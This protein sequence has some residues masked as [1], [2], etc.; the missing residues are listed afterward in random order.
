LD[1]IGIGLSLTTCGRVSH[2]TRPRSEI[3]LGA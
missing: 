2:I 1:F 3:H